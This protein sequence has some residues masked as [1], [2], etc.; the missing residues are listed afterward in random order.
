ME[1]GVKRIFTIKAILLAT[2]LGGP[3]AAALL[4]SNNFKAFGNKLAARNALLWGITAT[5]IIFAVIFMLPEQVFQKTSSFLISTA[6]TL[7]VW[8]FVNQYQEQK[9]KEFLSEGG[10]KASNWKTFG[11]GLLGGVVTVL[12]LFLFVFIFPEKEFE[13]SVSVKDNVKLYHNEG[14]ED[15]ISQLI[16]TTIKQTGFIQDV[17][18][19]DLI[20]DAKDDYYNLKLLIVDTSIFT[21][22]AF[23]HA[24]KGFERELNLNLNLNKN[25]KVGFVDINLSKDYKLADLE[26]G[27]QY[28]TGPMRDLKAYQVNDFHTIMHNPSMPIEDVKKV[29]VTLKRLG[30]YFPVNKRIDI[31]FLNTGANYTI[32]FF[33]PKDDW[34]KEGLIDRLKGTVSD[35]KNNGIERPINLVLVDNQTFEEKQI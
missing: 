30:V 20:L 4:I 29:E 15:E 10:A 27:E 21:D 19:A 34:D 26:V 16:A 23:I 18:D 9:I 1:K 6:Y 33:V 14:I 5:F 8:F 13:R 35:I 12:F 28:Q 25:I 31:I 11:Y 32:K 24:V 17:E 3:L 22:R 2:F 7:I